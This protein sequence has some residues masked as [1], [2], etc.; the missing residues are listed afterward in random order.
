MVVDYDLR[1]VKTKQHLLD[2][3]G[4]DEAIFDS[5][6]SF[7]PVAYCRQRTESEITI[8]SVPNFIMHEIPK[9]NAARGKRV[10]WEPLLCKNE[11]KATTRRLEIF[12]Q[13]A[14]VGY[15]HPNAYGYVKGRNI[16]ENAFQHVGKRNLLKI[17]VLEFFPT[18]KAEHIKS[19]FDSLGVQKEIA[20]YLAEFMTIGNELAL[21]LPTSPVLSNAYCFSM[22]CELAKL[23]EG[24][25]AEFTRYADDITFSSDDLLPSIGQIEEIVGKYG[26]QLAHDK[27]RR[28]TIG[29][30]HYV[31][32]LSVSDNKAPHAPR[33]LKRSLRQ[34]LYFA[35]KFG[36]DE[37]L[38][39]LGAND[40]YIIQAAINSLDGLVKYVA[41]HEPRKT[42]RLNQQWALILKKSG[43]QKSF[44][45]KN[46]DR[47]LIRMY[48]DETEFEVQGQHYLALALSV[49][50][51]QD[52]INLATKEILEDYFASP[53]SD[54][55]RELI[56][57]RGMH[58]SD[59]TEDLRL[60]FI[61]SLQFM[62]FEGFVAYAKLDDHSQYEQT[63][64]KL[65][66]VMIRR[67]LI[68]SDGYFACLFFEENSKVS[69]ESIDSLVGQEHKKLFR[70][71]NRRP[72][73]VHCQSVTKM[74]PGVAVPD[75]MLGVFR[76]YAISSFVD[77]RKPT[78]REHLMF[79]RLRDKYKLIFDADTGE[80]YGRRQPFMPLIRM[81]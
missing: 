40:S 67:R 13:K 7:D 80:E 45:P 31:T 72:E 75:F 5:V 29:Q 49:S 57:K 1:R 61:E 68:A 23:S 24:V 48:F 15:P 42:A 25:G 19:L 66:N 37:H 63:Y 79:E 3:I 74:T 8:S 12:F 55:D 34:E 78:P 62:P 26:F 30:A 14:I 81:Q 53:W 20:K 70:E 50:L 47:K 43:H 65:I 46:R 17:D 2:F 39:R 56:K 64:L 6:V 10:V 4:I 77:G 21:G 9:K 11:Y 60:K 36:L 69:L 28:S 27:T 16:R 59:A 52:K 73:A 58:F 44:I 32:G 38:N 35:E 54:G 18:I 33:K 76:R 22:D 51:H 71:N 41:Y